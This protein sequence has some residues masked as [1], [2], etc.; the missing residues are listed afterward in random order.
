VRIATFNV[1]GIRACVRRGF[2]GW[3]HERNPGIVLL[4][5]VRC[6]AALLPTEVWDGY[7]L[8]Y[9]EGARAGRNGVAVLSRDE[10]MAVR[11][12]LGS[13]EFDAEGRY[14]EIDLPGLTVAS[15]YL[16]KGDVPTGDEAALV[17]YDRKMRFMTSLRAHLTRSRRRAAEGGR[18]FL[19]GGDLNIAHENI[20]LKNW[21]TNR[22]N[23]G[24][25]PEERA[26]FATI[27]G[28]RTLHDVVRRLH[29]DVPGPYSWWSWR[30]QAWTTNAGWR[31]DYQLATPGLSARALTG[32][33][34]R[35]PSYDERMSDHSPVVV[36]YRD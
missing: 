9:D 30:G 18:E 31:I 26:W 29:P 23:A 36:D 15:L 13:R 32:G 20:D 3:L 6:P 10:P 16:P 1:N 21:R 35:E 25:L 34:D 7:H 24:F 28:P 8:A 5:E 2:G 27:L 4:Q 33:T 12:G 19:V 22:R 14:I 11:A 17:R